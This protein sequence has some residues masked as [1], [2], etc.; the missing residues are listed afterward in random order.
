[1]A[2]CYDILQITPAALDDA[3]DPAQALKRAYRRALLLHH[4]DKNTN[5]DRQQ[6]PVAPSGGPTVDQISAAFA[7]L[8]DPRRRADHDLALKR[9]SDRSGQAAGDLPAGFRTGIENVDLDDLA[10]DDG[11]DGGEAARW[12]RSCRCGNPRGYT[13]DE[14]DLEE[15]ADGG[16]LMVGCQDCSL[17]LR[18]HFAVVDDDDD[19]KLRDDGVTNEVG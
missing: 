10:M 7:V 2:S 4:P 11:A 5:P 19:A 9:G 15:A 1:M 6:Q 18:V 8:S 3:S 14:T 16:E 13:F 12:Y 17:W